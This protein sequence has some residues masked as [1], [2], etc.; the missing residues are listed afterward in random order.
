MT[1]SP[2]LSGLPFQVSMRSPDMVALQPARA[3]SPARAA[4]TSTLRSKAPYGGRPTAGVWP[5]HRPSEVRA[6]PHWAVA[7][8]R[9]SLVR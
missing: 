8:L 4:A 5:S 6:C 2:G 9:V 7:W 3:V 1:I